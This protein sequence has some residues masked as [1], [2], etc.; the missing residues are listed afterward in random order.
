[1]RT[2]E[3]LEKLKLAKE[4][5]AATSEASFVA[6]AVDILIEVLEGMVPRLGPVLNEAQSKALAM[7]IPYGRK[8]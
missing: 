3:M 4:K 5:M 7:K 8:P 1:M 6:D 2:I